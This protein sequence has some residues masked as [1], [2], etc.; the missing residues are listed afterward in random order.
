MGL[1]DLIWFSTHF[2]SSLLL[3]KLVLHLAR[4]M[5]S[6]RA[7]IF[8]QLEKEILHL[9]RFKPLHAGDIDAGLGLIKEAF[10]NSSFPT[11]AIHEF[12]CSGNENSTASSGFIAGIM[13]SLMKCGAPSVW[14]TASRLI[15]PPALKFFGIDPQ[16]IIFIQTKKPKDLLWTIEEALKCDSVCSVVGEIGEI[17]LFE[18]RRLQLAVEE[19]KVTGFVLRRNPKNLATSFVT[20]WRIASLPSETESN[21][22]GVGFP[23]WNVELLKVRNGKPGSWRMSWKNGQFELDEKD[24]IL[25]EVQEE[26]QRKIV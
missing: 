1:C 5:V 12:F 25:F 24:K 13:S 17:N 22:P 6:T 4:V 14:V 7:N 2:F 23:K 3:K 18:S 20:R 16:K 8:S 15:F 9:Q 10:P 26:A 19:S 21:L 11:G